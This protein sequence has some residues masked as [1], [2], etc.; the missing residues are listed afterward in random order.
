MT[1]RLSSVSRWRIVDG[2]TIMDRG[3]SA[4][5]SGTEASLDPTL[6]A[7][8]W[9]LV[10]GLSCAGRPLSREGGRALLCNG[11]WRAAH[12]GRG[13][14]L[15]QLRPFRPGNR[16]GKLRRLIPTGASPNQ[17]DAAVAEDS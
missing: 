9:L 17:L 7:L 1:R 8:A 2:L 3:H 12:S 5:A 6:L 4:A 16:P 15:A 14:L 13:S 10:D 11:L